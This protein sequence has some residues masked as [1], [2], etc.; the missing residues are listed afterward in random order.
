MWIAI[1][2]ALVAT[3]VIG[4]MF[5][6]AWHDGYSKAEDDAF[7]RKELRYLNCQPLRLMKGD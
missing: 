3:G 2:V 7:R 1:G 5:N 4:L 6:V